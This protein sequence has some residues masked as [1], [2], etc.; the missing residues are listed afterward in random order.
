[1]PKPDQSVM[2]NN[3]GANMPDVKLKTVFQFVFKPYFNRVKLGEGGLVIFNLFYSV[4]SQRNTQ[5]VLTEVLLSFFVLCALYGFNDY[6]DRVADAKNKKKEIAFIASIIQHERLFFIVNTLLTIL[7]I[8][9]AGF[10]LDHTKMV[11]VACLYIVNY[12]YS[13]KLKS[14]P[15]IDLVAVILWGALYV[16]IS[17]KLQIMLALV[18]GVMTGIAHLFQIITDKVADGEN[19][20]QTTIVAMPS[21]EIL[22]LS[23]LCAMLG[24]LLLAISNI[25]CAVSCIVPIVVYYVSNNVVFSWY[26]S[27][28]YFFICWLVL[29]NLYYGGF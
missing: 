11:V 5:V 27:R 1:M 2:N 24:G 17:G 26:V 6:N 23:A 12:A 3:A 21:K 18:V 29:L 7:T 10:F 16:T 13:L 20:I 28:V 25:W 9:C 8:I 19:N 14:I 15:F 4:F 22:F